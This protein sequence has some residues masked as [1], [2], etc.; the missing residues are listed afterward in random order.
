M[1]TLRE[2]Y[3]YKVL[4][5]DDE[6]MAVRAIC[7]IIEKSCPLFEVVGEAGNGEQALEQIRE[8]IPDVVLTD[9]EMPLMNG[10]EMAKRAKDTCSD[11]CFVVISGYQDYEYM[12]QAIQSGVLDYLAKPIVPSAIIA[13]MERVREKLLEQFYERRNELLRRIGQGQAVIKEE[14][15]RYFPFRLFYAGLVRENGLPRRF[16]SVGEPE[17]FG[18]GQ[19]AFSV[20]GR[21]SREQLFIIPAAILEHRTIRDYLEEAGSIQK[22]EGSYMTILY[23]SRP[24][25]ADVMAERVGGLYRG[26]SALSTVGVTQSQ[27]LETMNSDIMK[28]MASCIVQPDELMRELER[29]ASARQNDLVR[30]YIEKAYDSWGKA[31]CPQLWMENASRRILYFLRRE[32]ARGDDWLDSEYQLEEVFYNATDMKM[33]RE[34]LHSLF[35]RFRFEQQ[36]KPKVDS[37]EFFEG[38]ELYLKEHISEPVSLQELSDHFAISQAYIS[39]LFRKYAGRSFAQYLT[40]LRMEQAKQIMQ[41]H[42]EIFVRDVAALTG[43]QDQFYFSRIF[44]SYEGMSPAEYLSS[45][46]TS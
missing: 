30:K 44:R 41:D 32:N 10:L 24:F 15:A 43:Y 42:P 14:L 8:T 29:Y 6:P 12:R 1:D 4:V 7:R 20:Y 16:G 22:Q 19:E 35:F 2:A 27:D 26:L 37:P 9:I 39:K 36:E 18:T 25:T 45:C 31:G 13:M 28:P 23:Y 17:L 46:R 34:N 33:L 5:V 3:K 21:D 40:R 11:L 38:V